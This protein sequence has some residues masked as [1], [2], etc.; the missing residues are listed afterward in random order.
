MISPGMHVIDYSMPRTGKI[1]SVES[2][3][4]LVI[5]RWHSC[6]KQVARFDELYHDI[7]SGVLEYQCREKAPNKA[8]QPARKRK[9]SLT[10]QSTEPAPIAETPG[11]AGMT[12]AREALQ[13]LSS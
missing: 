13:K 1:S 7:G 12:I 2:K 4:K 9:P 8:Q 5:I 10:G 3:R 6:S 11:Q